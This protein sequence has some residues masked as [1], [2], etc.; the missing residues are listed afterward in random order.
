MHKLAYSKITKL[1]NVN[2][3][4]VWENG[5]IISGINGAVL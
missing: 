4:N 2:R 5:A 1:E 3:E